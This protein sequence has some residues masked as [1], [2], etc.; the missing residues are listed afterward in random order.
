MQKRV[1]LVDL[2]KS[3]LFFL[4]SKSFPT[5]IYLQKSASIQPRTSYLIFI[6]LAASMDLIFTERSS[7]CCIQTRGLSETCNKDHR[8]FSKLMPRSFFSCSC[9]GSCTGRAVVSLAA[10]GEKGRRPR[11]TR[12]KRRCWSRR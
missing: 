2:V 3:F 12:W 9:R 11:R 10:A 1:N 5:N 8:G 6:I 7:P 4:F